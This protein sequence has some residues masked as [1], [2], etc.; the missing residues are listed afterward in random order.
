MN[1][2]LAGLSPAKRALLEKMMKARAQ[3]GDPREQPIPRRPPGETVALSYNQE[4]LWILDQLMP[5]STAYNVPR[6]TRLYGHLDV[7]ALRKALDT[8]AARHEAIRTTY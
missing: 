1:D 4:I 5:G 7:D 8:I 6:A 2:K 3:A